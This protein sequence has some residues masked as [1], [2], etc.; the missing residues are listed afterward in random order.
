MPLADYRTADAGS[1]SDLQL[2]LFLLWQTPE[3]Q[4]A[5]VKRVPSVMEHQGSAHFIFVHEGLN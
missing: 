1:D 4:Q 3:K 5:E 2:S